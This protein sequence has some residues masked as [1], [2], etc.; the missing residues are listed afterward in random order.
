MG[1]MFS[2]GIKRDKPIDQIAN[3][4]DGLR[5]NPNSRYH[6]VSTW[7]VADVPK[8]VLPTCHI[9]FQCF[10]ANNKLS[11]HINQRSCDM[12]LGVPFNLASYAT[13]TH[14]LAQ[15]CDLKVGELVWTGMD[16]HI[17]M[18]HFAQVKE[19]LSR[20]PYPLPTLVLNPDI[21]EIDDFTM[22]DFTL[23]NYQCHPTIEA[24]I[25]V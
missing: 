9:L 13:L 7:N 22:D 3:L 14:M 25:A 5:N 19:Q 17:Y 23:E 12:F 16:A 20:K 21:K 18:N 10:V 6:V 2:S 4:V 11:L 8:M 1:G 24:E 15:V